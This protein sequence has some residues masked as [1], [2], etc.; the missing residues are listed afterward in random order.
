MY[1]RVR[2]YAIG[3]GWSEPDA[4]L[5][6]RSCLLAKFPYA[7]G[8]FTYWFRRFTRHELRNIEYRTAVVAPPHRE[9]SVSVHDG[10]N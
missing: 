4:R 8:L 10:Q 9:L 5:F 3:R 1:W 2:R 6:A 7:W